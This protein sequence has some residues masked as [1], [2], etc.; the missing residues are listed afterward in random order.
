M[1]HSTLA[2]EL[3]SVGIERGVAI[4][5]EQLDESPG[6]NAG[7]AAVANRAFAEGVAWWRHRCRVPRFPTPARRRL[8]NDGAPRPWTLLRAPLWRPTST[9]CSELGAVCPVRADTVARY[10]RPDQV[11]PRQ[12][13]HG[14]P[15]T[16]PTRGELHWA[17]PSFSRVGRILRSPRYA[18]AFVY[19]RTRVERQ[20]DGTER[21]RV[22]PMEE[23]QVC[24]PSAHVGFIDREE[25][26]RNQATMASNA[27]AFLPSGS[28][29]AAPREGRH[30]CSRGCGGPPPPPCTRRNRRTSSPGAMLLAHHHVEPRCPRPVLLTDPAVL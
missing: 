24:I 29:T 1:T 26:L 22:V 23:W 7:V 5:V 4:G 11:R 16:T 28:R 15:D 12:P 8:G 25:Y 18:G 10:G 6:K 21:H 3:R 30:C 13:K 9:G 19:G 14:I 17:L 27:A 2:S 20:V